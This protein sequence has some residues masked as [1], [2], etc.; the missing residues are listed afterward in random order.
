MKFL[1]AP[2]EKTF[3]AVAVRGDIDF[4]ND[5]VV[6]RIHES[7]VDEQG[8]TRQTVK[9]EDIN[10]DQLL[11]QVNNDQA[12]TQEVRVD[13]TLDLTSLNAKFVNICTIP[14]GSIVKLALFQIL[15]TVTSSSTTDSLGI[16]DHTQTVVS[17]MLQASATGG[18][19]KNKQASKCQRLASVPCDLNA[20]IAS[21][22][23]VGGGNITAGKVRVVIAY[24]TPAV[25][26]NV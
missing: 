16:G 18:L 6:A 2:A 4:Y 20:T 7:R 24:D 9:S 26:P 25:L 21:S 22:G 10:I 5:T 19:L 23:Q 17:A 3:L 14:A 13:K 15:E 12:G 8:K 11:A 1:N